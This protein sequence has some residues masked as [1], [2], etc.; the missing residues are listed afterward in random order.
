[1]DERLL[2]QQVDADGTLPLRNREGWCDR[3]RSYRNH[4]DR[5]AL[6]SRSAGCRHPGSRRPSYGK[7]DARDDRRLV[8]GSARQGTGGR[9]DTGA[10]SSVGGAGRRSRSGRNKGSRSPEAGHVAVARRPLSFNSP[11]SSQTA[12]SCIPRITTNNFGLTLRLF[13][14]SAVPSLAEVIRSQGAQ[15]REPCPWTE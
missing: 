5:C 7:S 15:G 14:V 2:Y 3:I 10:A 4:Q 13:N 1:M 6:S 9:A 11:Y 8:Q 12:G